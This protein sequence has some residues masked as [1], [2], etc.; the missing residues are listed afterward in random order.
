MEDWDDDWKIP[1]T[2]RE[3]SKKQ[4]P[5]VQDIDEYEEEGEEQEKGNGTG[6]KTQ[7]TVLHTGEKRKDEDTRKESTW[8][9]KRKVVREPIVQALVEDDL[10]KIEN[11]VKETTDEAFERMTKQKEERHLDMQAQIAILRQFLETTP[12]ATVQ[13]G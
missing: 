2:N 10:D 13:T 5:E 3:H 8:H 4:N 9:K 12:L 7:K 1:T 6:K 11:Q